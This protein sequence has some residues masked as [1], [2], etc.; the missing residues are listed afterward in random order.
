M[1]S[2]VALSSWRAGMGSFEPVACA[3]YR[4]V[5]PAASRRRSARARP[6]V[7][8]CSSWNEIAVATSA[9]TITP[10]KK[11][12]GSWKRR[13]RN[14]PALSLYPPL[15]AGSRAGETL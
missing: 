13:E 4:R 2:P 10:A 1:R 11:R 3:A 7:Y 14:M 8:D 12:A 9:K 6:I 5:S 15:V